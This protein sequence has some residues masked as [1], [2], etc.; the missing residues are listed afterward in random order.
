MPERDYSYDEMQISNTEKRLGANIASFYL[1]R[2]MKYRMRLKAGSDM[3]VTPIV[4]KAREA[5]KLQDSTKNEERP[6]SD[7]AQTAKTSSSTNP[8]MIQP[9]VSINFQTSEN[10]KDTYLPAIAVTQTPKSGGGHVTFKPKDKFNPLAVKNKDQDG[11]VSKRY[12]PHTYHPGQK[13]GSHFERR[14]LFFEVDDDD[15]DA[16]LP[17]RIDLHALFSRKDGHGDTA[18]W[19][20]S[21][22]NKHLDSINILRRSQGGYAPKV[23]QD[24]IQQEYQQVKVKVDRFLQELHE[25]ATRQSDYD[26]DSDSG[27]APTDGNQFNTTITVP[28]EKATS[29]INSHENNSISSVAEQTQKVTLDNM[30]TPRIPKNAWK[31]IRGRRFDGSL[32]GN[33][34]AEDLVFQTLTGVPLSR[35]SMTVG[36]PLHAASRAMR[37]TATFKMRKVIEKLISDRTKYQRHEI[38]ELKKKM[39][40]TTA[41]ENTSRKGSALEV[42]RSPSQL[43]S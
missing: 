16:L 25:H 1:E 21:M 3:I 4:R 30:A 26:S 8:S 7:R 24:L 27:N 28:L 41:D 12:R 14:D 32:E 38:Q 36:I 40:G 42:Q 18:A 31:Y 6:T 5:L 37:H 9:A 15:D 22:P 17:D 19:V 33:Q 29:M 35:S 10:R 2:K 11:G 13:E 20:K 39:E 43:T 34:T 23:T